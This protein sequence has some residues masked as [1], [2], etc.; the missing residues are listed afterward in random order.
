MALWKSWKTVFCERIPRTKE[1]GVKNRHVA[2]ATK[3]RVVFFHPKSTLPTIIIEV[4]MGP[5]NNSFISFGVVVHFHDYGRKGTSQK[6]QLWFFLSLCR[7]SVWWAWLDF[8]TPFICWN[9][10]HESD[11]MVAASFQPVKVMGSKCSNSD[12]SFVASWNP[13]IPFFMTS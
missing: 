8:S 4:K 6:Q 1:T 12:M 11:L 5:S 3:S 7:F 9:Q 13:G 10:H 2:P